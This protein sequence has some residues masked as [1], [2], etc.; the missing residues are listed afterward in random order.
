[1]CISVE[2]IIINHK[3]KYILNF[4][5]NKLFLHMKYSTCNLNFNSTKIYLGPAY[6]CGIVYASKLLK[7]Y[8]GYNT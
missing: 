3:Q 6:C 8:V 4:L 1:M 2:D 7:W 5:R